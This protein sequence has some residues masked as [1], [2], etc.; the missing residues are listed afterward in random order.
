MPTNRPYGIIFISSAIAITG[1]LWWLRESPRVSGEDVAECY[2]A[3]VERQIVGLYDGT[4]DP[5]FPSNPVGPH[6]VFDTL[7]KDTLVAARTLATN[8]HKSSRYGRV[9]WLQAQEALPVSGHVLCSNDSSPYVFEVYTND[10]LGYDM[11]IPRYSCTGRTNF[12]DG[13]LTCG[14]RWPMPGYVMTPDIG[15]H[16]NLPI[17]VAVE[18]VYWNDYNRTI[19]SLAASAAGS[20]WPVIGLGTNS[21]KYSL[22]YYTNDIG[23]C[24]TLKHVT[25]QN[26]NEARSVLSAMTRTMWVGD[27]RDMLEITDNA[28]FAWRS[29]TYFKTNYYDTVT[30]ALDMDGWL[31]DNWSVS[32]EAEESLPMSLYV[33]LFYISVSASGLRGVTLDDYPGGDDDLICSLEYMFD[34]N[35]HVRKLTGCRLPYPSEYAC[36]SGYVSRVSIYALAVSDSLVLSPVFG[37]GASEDPADIDSITASGNLGWPD[38]WSGTLYGVLDAASAFRGPAMSNELTPAGYAVYG[39]LMTSALYPPRVMSLIATVDNPST[40]PVFE[41]GAETLALVQEQMN[42][43][44]TKIESSH[45]Y[46]LMTESRV[47]EREGREITHM[48]YVTHFV[49]IVDWN[50]KHLNDAAPFVPDAFTPGW[51]TSNTNVP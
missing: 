5:S 33:D 43:Y 12:Y 7:Y 41:L 46:E 15:D 17:S 44:S 26:L 11:I 39:T 9:L 8:S 49:V 47:S 25:T 51:I 50:W 1:S 40:R 27:A 36:A 13:L 3:L 31:S 18:G 6:L 20:W 30:P 22:E 48:L 23:P 38:R 4:G 32:F 10:S 34:A 14:S 2:A 19:S 21:Y 28:C 42:D 37:W 45:E 16:T 35:A 29:H 24:A